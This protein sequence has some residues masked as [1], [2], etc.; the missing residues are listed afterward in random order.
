[1]SGLYRW[2]S[3]RHVGFFCWLV[4]D[5]DHFKNDFLSLGMILVTKSILGTKWELTQNLAIKMAFSP[6][7]FR[8]IFKLNLR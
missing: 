6:F 4:D 5:K 8:L 1:M 2:R 7:G 3:V